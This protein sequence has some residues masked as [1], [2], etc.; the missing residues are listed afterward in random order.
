MR[1]ITEFSLDLAQKLIN[2][3]DRFPVDFDDAWQWLEYSEKAKAKRAI[4][5]DF[6]A[7]IDFA[8][9]GEPTT[10]GI[11]A[12]PEEKIWLTISCFKELAMLRRNEKGKMVRKYF[13]ECEQIAQK[14]RLES[15]FQQKASIKEIDDCAAIFGKRFGSLYEQRYLI[16]QFQKHHP[17]LLGESP[18]YE[19]LPSA[20][21]WLTPTQLA[22]ELG[23]KYKTGNPNPQAVNSLLEKLGYQIKTAAGWSATEKAIADRLCDRKPVDTNSRSQKDQLLWSEEVISRLVEFA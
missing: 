17:H 18:A 9:N 14:L 23:F 8:I 5:R 1:N 22:A 6:I 12:H 15:Q 4:L 20:K 13:L 3:A 2:S 21:S 19:S 10:M 7:D 11:Q 16:Q